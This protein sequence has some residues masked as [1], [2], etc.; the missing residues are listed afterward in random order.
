MNIHI[1]TGRLNRR[2]RATR[3]G[4]VLIMTLVMIVLVALSMIALTR[5]S[6][7]RA[8]NAVDAQAKLQRKWGSISCRKIFLV[9]ASEIFAGLEAAHL[10]RKLPWPAPANTR[11]VFN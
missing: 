6:L 2:A 10:D 8:V 1:K 7:A 9:E 11:R 3:S 5:F 4:Y